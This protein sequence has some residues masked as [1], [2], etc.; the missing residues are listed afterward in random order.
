[1]QK[2]AVALHGFRNIQTLKEHIYFICTISRHDARTPELIRLLRGDEFEGPKPL[3]L[4]G[5]VADEDIGIAELYRLLSAAEAGDESI[6]VRLLSS[7]SVATLEKFVE[8]VSGLREQT[9]Q[10]PPRGRA[11]LKVDELYP[12]FK[13]FVGARARKPTI[14]NMLPILKQFRA[15]P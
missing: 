15:G 1:M 10:H 5:S 12:L 9:K 2:L 7:L 3:P 4:P 14:V 8:A 11:S 13:H 6:T